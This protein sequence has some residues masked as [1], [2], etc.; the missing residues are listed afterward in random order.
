V[1]TLKCIA[2]IAM[3]NLLKTRIAANEG[4][5]VGTPRTINAAAVT[6]QSTFNNGFPQTSD[7]GSQ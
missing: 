1:A 6:Y 4:S 2:A 5:A 3:P 7:V